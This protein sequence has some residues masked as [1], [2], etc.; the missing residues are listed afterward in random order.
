MAEAAAA[1]AGAAEEGAV[2]AVDASSGEDQLLL[3]NPFSAN[4][5]MSSCNNKCFVF[6]SFFIN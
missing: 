2:R 6:F 5:F 1:E 4:C 3:V